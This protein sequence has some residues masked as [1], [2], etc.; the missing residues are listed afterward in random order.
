MQVPLT[1][2]GREKKERKRATKTEIE[3]KIQGT[4]STLTTDTK[5]RSTTHHHTYKTQMQNV[6]SPNT[7]SKQKQ[8][9]EVTRCSPQQHKRDAKVLNVSR[10]SCLGMKLCVC[11]L[12]SWYRESLI[13]VVEPATKTHTN[14][15]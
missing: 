9:P 14:K 2:L 7:S 1:H 6:R 3:S 15:R 4:S 5:P 10:E 12:Q 11:W 13:T 8:D